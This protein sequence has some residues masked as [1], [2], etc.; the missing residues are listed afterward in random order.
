MHINSN[1]EA[2]TSF[3]QL[4]KEYQ[5][6]FV[7]FAN[8]YVR[9]LAMAEDITVEALM[10]Y[11][12]NQHSLE[13]ESNVPAYILTVIKHKCLNY[14]RH[15]QIH[16]EYSQNMQSYAEWELSTRIA[17][18]QACEPDEL[19]AAE[20]REIVQRTLAGLPDKT[21]EIFILNRYENKSYKE[22]AVQMGMTTKGVEFH[23][24]KALKA[25]HVNLKDYFPFLLYFFSKM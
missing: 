19:F 8:T 20:V 10:Y 25:L 4:Y 17:T 6:R 15:L 23:I 18:L 14:L 13:K 2:L 9:D 5:M 11:W 12:E 1:T 21:R 16:E 24:S 22:I 3:N 7:R